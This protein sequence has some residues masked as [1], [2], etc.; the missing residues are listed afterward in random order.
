MGLQ[1]IIAELKMKKD[2]L[3]GLIGNYRQQLLEL[4]LDR[5]DDGEDSDI[6]K[7]AAELNKL[8]EKVT[9][10]LG[11]VQKS[12]QKIDQ[13]TFGICVS[14]GGEISL[15]RLKALPYA[16]QCIDCLSETERVA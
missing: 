5:G 3:S 7:R 13:G 15:R 6:Q 11:L 14:C 9:Q 10:E 2:L 4:N 8:I 12:L 16:Q 1:E